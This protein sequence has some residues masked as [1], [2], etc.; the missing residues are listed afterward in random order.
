MT[1]LKTGLNVGLKNIGLNKAKGSIII[2]GNLDVGVLDG[3]SLGLGYTTNHFEWNDDFK[4]ALNDTIAATPDSIIV[5]AGVSMKRH[6]F[7]IRALYHLN[8]SGGKHDFYGGGRLGLT[9]WK[10]EINADVTEVPLSGFKFPATL[11]SIQLLVGYRY[12]FT[13][14]TGINIELGAGTAPYFINAGLSFA[15]PGA[16]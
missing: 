14:Y 12:F 16:Y 9:I 5:N 13:P 11:P 8:S 3:F 1:T 4:Q 6:N 7:G 2:N 15:I 10:T